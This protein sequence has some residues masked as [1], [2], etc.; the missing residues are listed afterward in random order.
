[1]PPFVS[2]VVSC[3]VR[4]QSRT[5]MFHARLT[6]QE[7]LGAATKYVKYQAYFGDWVSVVAWFG[8]V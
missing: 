5:G 4:F 8:S 2:I 7:G 6:K 3:S 1:M